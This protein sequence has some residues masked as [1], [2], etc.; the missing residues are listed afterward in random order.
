MILYYKIIIVDKLILTI[1][2][3]KVAM[4]VISVVIVVVTFHLQMLEHE[5]EVS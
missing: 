4:N 2:I 1:S 3:N 5:R